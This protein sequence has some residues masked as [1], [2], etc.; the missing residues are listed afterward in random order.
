MEK[1]GTVPAPSQPFTFRPPA[2][3]D[4][5]E[6]LALISR[7]EIAEYGE[8]DADITDLMHDWDQI[9][10]A[11]DAVLAYSPAGKL[12]GYAA[13]TPWGPGYRYHFYADPAW[14]TVELGRALLARC[15]IRG[16]EAAEKRPDEQLTA[17]TYIAHINGRDREI[18]T[19]AGF[20]LTRYH[21]QMRIEMEE[22]PP[23]PH[24][25][26]GITVRSMTPGQDERAIYDLIE[27]AFARPGREG[28]SFEEWT[29][30]MVRSDIFDPDLWFL[31]VAGE[32]LIGACLCFEYP[33][34]G[35]VRQ[36]GVTESWRR[37][38]LGIALLQH[39]FGAFYRRGEKQ[40]G[41]SVAAD[42]ESAYT[43]YQRAGMRRARQ[44]DEYVKPLNK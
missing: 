34:L 32:R 43:F 8:P 2:K 15:E 36:L 35:W 13:V 27:E 44:Y 1:V 22:P 3:D 20:E 6:T 14:E 9:D 26:E 18:V 10:L 28:P 21:F 12:V 40:V 11:K 30:L 19:G 37:K 24:W 29:S 17:K 41:L 33:G 42:N 16:E 5:E 4:A 23:A 31:A 38:G 39:A 7:C 25:P